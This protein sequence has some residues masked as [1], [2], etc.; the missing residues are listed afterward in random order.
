MFICDERKEAVAQYV[1]TVRYEIQIRLDPSCTL[2]SLL[3]IPGETRDRNF[4]LIVYSA[5]GRS[6]WM[7]KMEYMIRFIQVHETF[8][9]PELEALGELEN[10][11]FEIVKYEL[12]VCTPPS[13]LH[14]HKQNTS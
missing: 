2:Q 1:V 3:K 13:P 4:L 8:R 6:L 5:P 9:L 7:D 14:P 11:Q 12:D 10:V